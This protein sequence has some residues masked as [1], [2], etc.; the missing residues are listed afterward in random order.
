MGR[1]E[2]HVYCADCACWS[3]LIAIHPLPKDRPRKFRPSTAIAVVIANMVGTGVFTSLGFQLV[4]IQS[5]F[6]L[7]LLW[8]VGGLT[9]LCGALTYAEL[10]ATLPRSGG[11]YNFLSQIYHPAAGFISGWISA[12]IGFAAPTAL[13]AITFSRYL[14]SVIPQVNAPAVACLLVLALTT[15]HTSTHRNSG[16]VQRV[17]TA[18]KVVIILI[19]CAAALITT[20][21]PQPVNF[22][23]VAHDGDLIFGGAFAVSLIYVNYAYSG[24]NAATYITSEV[25]RPQ[26]TLPLALLAGTGVVMV[27]Y[28]LLNF[29]FLYAAPMDA[30]SGTV[31][32]GYVA[33]QYAFGGPGAK[34]MGLILSTLLISTVSAMIIAG[35]RVLQVIGEDF[36]ILGFLARTNQDGLP[37]W[38][39]AT[40][41]LLSI[42]FILSATFEQILVFSGFTMTVSSFLTVAGIYVLRWRDPGRE[43]PY[44]AF[45]YPLTPLVYLLL[46]GWTLAYIIVDRPM[47]AL[48]GLGLIALGGLFYVVSLKLDM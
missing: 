7:M 37:V 15:V 27:L 17:F 38:A 3:L 34:I 10:G 13:A 9:A 39:I 31:E 1:A 4:D 35:P 45:L 48:A 24:W 21:K 32:I 43:R 30:M 40:Q 2:N 42:A 44:R 29:T 20:G 22:L 25:D 23:P 36:R 5:G 41:S 6:P 46:T 12:T 28:L 8:A 26:K 11:E 19:F 18:I 33:A 47:E 14:S 16:E